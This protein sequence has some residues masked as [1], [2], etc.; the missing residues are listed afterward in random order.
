MLIKLET[1]G[2]GVSDFGIERFRTP[3]VWYF[4]NSPK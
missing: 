4:A 2:F 1:G 3:F